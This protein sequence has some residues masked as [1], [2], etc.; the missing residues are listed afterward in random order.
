MTTQEPELG[1]LE[2]VDPRDA[3]KHE[4]LDFTPWLAGNLGRLAAVLGIELELQDSE[5]YVGTYRADIVA[6][7]PRDGSRVLIEN[8]LEDADLQH[9]GQLLAYLPGLEAKVVV[10]IA[11]DF[12]EPNLSAIRWLNDHTEDQYAFFAIRVRLARIGTSPLAPVFDVRQRPNNWDRR[13]RSAAQHGDFSALHQFYREFWSHVAERLSGDVTLGY[14]RAWV[15][16][17]VEEADRRIHLYVRQSD[18]RDVGVRLTKNSDE[19]DERA[20]SR[21]E[22]YLKPLREATKGEHWVDDKW[23]ESRLEIDTRD[24]ANWNRIADWLHERLKVYKRVLRDTEV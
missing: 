9:L 16:T 1:K 12:D 23:G 13:V 8:Q 7:D 3:W 21:I 19:T 11:K 15:H 22:P 24:R 20:L 4:A 10:W 18:V 17:F 6:T 14:A 2:W 5:V